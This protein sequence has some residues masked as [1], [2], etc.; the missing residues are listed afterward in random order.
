M[1]K[2]NIDVARFIYDHAVTDA[3][4]EPFVVTHGRGLLVAPGVTLH[5][6]SRASGEMV[7]I[8]HQ[9]EAVGADGIVVIS[10]REYESLR[11]RAT[12]RARARQWRDEAA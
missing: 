4:A 9:V 11:C 3:T 6:Y 7:R 2:E 8:D 1:S 12:R 10:K 5:A